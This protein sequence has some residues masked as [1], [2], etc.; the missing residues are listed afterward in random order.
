MYVYPCLF[1]CKEETFSSDLFQL[2]ISHKKGDSS[3]KEPFNTV[4]QIVM[5]HLSCQNF[6]GRRKNFTLS[7]LSR[8]TSTQYF[9][10]QITSVFKLSRMHLGKVG[11]RGCATKPSLLELLLLLPK[12]ESGVESSLWSQRLSNR[13]KGPPRLYRASAAARAAWIYM[14]KAKKTQK[15]T[16]IVENAAEVDFDYT[17]L[18]FQR[19]RR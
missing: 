10:C 5:S 9:S 18:E 11:K 16:C 14:K 8:S 4:G 3:Q 6:Q 2:K 15:M 7:S 19:Q 17:A 12:E 13:E 1:A